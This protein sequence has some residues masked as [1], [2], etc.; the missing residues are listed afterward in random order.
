MH[1]SHWQRRALGLVVLAGALVAADAASAACSSMRKINIG[2]SV[3]P[4]NV[5]HTSPYVAKELGFF[6]KHCIDATI[7]QF[8]G[9]GSA[10]S[11]AAAA[12]GTA[13]VS[14]QAIAVGNGVKVRQIWGLAPRLPQSYEVAA[15]VKT[16]KDLKG[17]RLSASGGGVG[18]LNWLMGREV[19]HTVGLTVNDVQFIAGGTA[20][21]L[22]G[23]VS[24]QV[25][26]VMLHPEDVYLAEKKKPGLH[27]LVD[28]SELL[29]KYMFNAY[30]A[31]TAWIEKDRPLMV[32]A[33]AAMI[34]ANRAMYRDKAKVVPIIMKATGKP[35]EAVEFAIDDLTKN[36]VWSVNEGLDKE[37]TQWSIDNDVKNGYIKPDK[38]PTVDQVADFALASDAVK[39]AGGRVTIGKCT[40]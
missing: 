38:K 14:V 9:G 12:Q 25:D 40:E 36:C 37:R 13:L 10:A 39:A 26:A 20:G 35:K 16:V 23:L 34:E 3:A 32:D 11:K 21:R 5:V 22:P 7:I 6:E 1:K 17:K 29:P 15:D 30:G 18:G 8:D 33:A 19:L 24:G 28:F 31:A 2:V 27:A 4:P